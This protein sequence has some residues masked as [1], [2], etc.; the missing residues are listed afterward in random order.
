MCE[1]KSGIVTNANLWVTHQYRDRG[2]G[3]ELVLCAIGEAADMLRK[4]LIGI[5]ERHR[6]KDLG[7]WRSAEAEITQMF[8]QFPSVS[9]RVVKP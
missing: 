9:E 7:G 4:H 3:S 1:M 6:R 5:L 2:N 8:E